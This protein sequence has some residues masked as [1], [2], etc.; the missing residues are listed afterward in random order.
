MS[1]PIEQA[2]GAVTW[3]EYRSKYPHSGSW[4]AW[5][6]GAAVSWCGTIRTWEGP[7]VATVAEVPA[8]AHG[9]QPLC[10]NCKRRVIYEGRGGS[11]PATPPTTPVRRT[12]GA[13]CAHTV[14]FVDG[15]WDGRRVTLYFVQETPTRFRLQPRVYEHRDVE[16]E[17]EPWK[18]P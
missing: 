16:V 8:N 6:S 7:P 3:R 11:H 13:V 10:G 18:R 9:Y 14:E 12:A 5:R 1:D 2:P 17:V 4:H 15:P